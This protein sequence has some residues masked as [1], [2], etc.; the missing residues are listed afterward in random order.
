MYTLSNNLS[1]FYGIR[2]VKGTRT[3]ENL[4]PFLALQ[5]SFGKVTLMFYALVSKC[6]KGS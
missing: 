5:S 3:K 2:V 4:V 1:I 6:I